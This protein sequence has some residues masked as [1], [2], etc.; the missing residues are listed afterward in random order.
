MVLLG[1]KI[2]KLRKFS[3]YTQ[4]ELATLLGVTKSTIAAYENDSRQPSYEVLIKI[5]KVFNISLDTLLIDEPGKIIDV[6]GLSDYQIHMLKNMVERLRMSNSLEKM[7]MSCSP[8]MKKEIE[9]FLEDEEV[10]SWD[11]WIG[12]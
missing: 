5:S 11:L 12:R 6:E 4:A 10:K 1:E 7:L 3:K 2:K 9:D 8:A